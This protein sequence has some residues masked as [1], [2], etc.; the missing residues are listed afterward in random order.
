MLAQ[1]LNIVCIYI[2]TVVC[3]QTTYVVTEI[4][5]HTS[6]KVKQASRLSKTSFVN[7]YDTSYIFGIKYRILGHSYF[8]QITF[9]GFSRMQ[10]H[11]L[12]QSLLF[13]H[14]LGAELQHF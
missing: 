5:A 7:S 12:Y 4:Q 8:I 14:F 10:K 2:D 3:L 9:I 11:Q 13:F 1:G 6:A